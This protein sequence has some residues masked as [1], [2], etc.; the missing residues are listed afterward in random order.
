MKIY[1]LISSLCALVFGLSVMCFGVYSATVVEYMVSGNIQYEAPKLAVTITNITSGDTIISSNL[2]IL[3]KNTP[4]KL[5]FSF[6]IQPDLTFADENHP[7]GQSTVISLDMESTINSPFARIF[8]MYEGQTV[9][10]KVNASSLYLPKNSKKIFKIYIS[11]SLQKPIDLKDLNIS[12]FYDEQESIIHGPN[13]LD[14]SS[15]NNYFYVEMGTI[16]KPNMTQN[17]YIKW[18]LIGLQTSPYDAENEIASKYNIFKETEL[19]SSTTNSY[20]VFILDSD[21]LIDREEQDKDGV[22]LQLNEIAFNTDYHGDY[23][24]EDYWNYVYANDYATSTAR[25]YINGINVYKVSSGTK[26]NYN[27]DTTKQYSNMYKDFNIDID[28]DLIFSQI[29]G[30]TL[31]DLYLNMSYVYDRVDFPE[32]L[33]KQEGYKKDTLDK[34]WLLSL[35][36]INIFFADDYSSSYWP[37]Q[38]NDL[39][40]LRTPNGVTHIS[41]YIV[42]P[43]YNGTYMVATS[44]LSA[45]PAFVLNLSDK[46]KF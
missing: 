11:N 6:Q 13:L 1:K 12:V 24:A 3:E 43:S 29:Q 44:Y 23:H 27:A 41:T 30:R 31:D 25:R 9:N 40:W 18:K 10:V 42:S 19:P 4:Y 16:M 36:E 22:D 21:T 33:L 28:N 39:Y 45:R 2:I 7:Q 38:V 26:P 8:V 15:D 46:N 20:G 32:Q 5:N 34:F 37:S 17:E 35:N 14:E